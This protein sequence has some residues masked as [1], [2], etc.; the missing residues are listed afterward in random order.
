M[1]KIGPIIF[2]FAL[3][4][5]ALPFVFPKQAAVLLFVGWAVAGTAALAWGIHLLAQRRWS[6]LF[7]LL[8]GLVDLLFLFPLIH[9][10]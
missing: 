3:L 1:N 7:F 6:G 8:L 10:S 2:S 4:C 5:V 9:H